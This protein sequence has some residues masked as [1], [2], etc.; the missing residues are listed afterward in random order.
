MTSLPDLYLPMCSHG[1]LLLACDPDDCP[2]TWLE[3][4][5]TRAQAARYEKSMRELSGHH[6]H[7]VIDDEVDY[8]TAK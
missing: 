5:H 8:R 2:E 3:I 4:E 7:W 1:K 6:L